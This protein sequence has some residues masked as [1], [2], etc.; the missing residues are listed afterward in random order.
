MHLEIEARFE[1]KS[2]VSKI[3]GPFEIPKA[4]QLVSLDDL[5]TYMLKYLPKNTPEVIKKKTN[6]PGG[7]D[8]LEGQVHMRTQMGPCSRATEKM[9]PPAPA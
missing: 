1:G 6:F 3:R 9:P 8:P 2:V 5:C 7:A 4:C